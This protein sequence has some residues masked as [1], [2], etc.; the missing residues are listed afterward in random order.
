MIKQKN[1]QNRAEKE[2]N[3]T[4][5]MN[6]LPEQKYKFLG[7]VQ[8]FAFVILEN[9]HGNASTIHEASFPLQEDA[10]EFIS[11]VIHKMFPSERF[12]I[13]MLAFFIL[14][15]FFLLCVPCI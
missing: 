9:F 5:G 13:C 7:N 12:S 10:L 4:T 15:A 6:I 11:F 8:K 2:L 3:S 14:L 1:K